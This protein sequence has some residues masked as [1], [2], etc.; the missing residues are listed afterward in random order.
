MAPLRGAVP[1]D[2]AVAT[3]SSTSRAHDCSATKYGLVLVN[4]SNLPPAL[5]AALAVD[6]YTV[7]VTVAVT[8]TVVS[9]P[10]PANA[11]IQAVPAAVSILLM[12]LVPS[13]HVSL[14]ATSPTFGSLLL[15]LAPEIKALTT[16][17]PQPC[18]FCVE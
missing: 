11:H 9:V 13:P 15:V 16:L 12:G 14:A 8:T 4:T 2:S 10:A 1:V 5:A 18:N 17:L 3:K 6:S 7:A